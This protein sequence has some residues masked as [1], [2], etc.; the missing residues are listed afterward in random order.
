MTDGRSEGDSPPVPSDPSLPESVTN[1]QSVADS[2]D[3]VTATESRVYVEL[4]ALCVETHGDSLDEAEQA[5]Y[6]V[7]EH[8]MA[9]MDEMTD[10]M[11]E[12]LGGYQ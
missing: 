5:F 6:R 8:I 3:T 4:G 2:D 1:G 11:R 7:W 10:A 9:D 12:R